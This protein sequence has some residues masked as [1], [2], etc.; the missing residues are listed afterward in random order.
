[1]T[2]RWGRWGAAVFAMALAAC[3]APP[4]PAPKTPGDIADRVTASDESD[5]SKRARVRMELAEAYFSRGEMTF[6]LD[7][8]KLAL[9]ANPNLAAAHNLRALIYA[10]MGDEKLAEESFRRALQVDPRDA[11]SLQNFGWFLCQEGRFPE[12]DG[13]FARAL[14][15]PQY[16]GTARTLLTQGVCQARG[17]QTAQAEATLS[18]ALELDPINPAIV[19]NLA[20][21]LYR[22]GDLER[23]RLQ[24]RRVNNT[25]D[26]A[27]AQTLWLAARIENR[28]GNRSGADELGSQLLRRYPASRE[29]A[30]FQ[31]GQFDE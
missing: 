7:Q 1:M 5:T 3:A 13:L 27:N 9:T 21:V 6:A 31:K 17:G 14:E 24:I 12:A 19:V 23:A 28:L 2:R 15:V 20:E 26:I 29:A 30:S 18:R 4:K 16:R 8:V 25:P 10:N 11:D 22:R